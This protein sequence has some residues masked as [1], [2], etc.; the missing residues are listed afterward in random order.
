MRIDIWAYADKDVVDLLER[1]TTSWDFEVPLEEALKEV[2]KVDYINVT[3][4]S[5]NTYEDEEE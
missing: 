3:L 2:L 4:K 1:N 5:I